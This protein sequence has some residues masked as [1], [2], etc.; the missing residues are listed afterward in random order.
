[1][2]PLRPGR[3]TDSNMSNA[4]IARSPTSD[5]LLYVFTFAGIALFGGASRPDALSQP[6]VRLVASL[7]IAYCIARPR[8]MDSKTLRWGGFL[9]GGIACLILIQLVPI[10]PALWTA[11]PGRASYAGV[12]ALTGTPLGWHAI[13]L[14]PDLGWNSFFS[15]LP[16]TAVLLCSARLHGR[17]SVILAA[18]LCAAFASALLG[19]FQ[20]VQGPESFHL[21]RGPEKGASGLFANRNHQALL[22]ACAIPLTA[23]WGSSSAK[24]WPTPWL[25]PAIAL[26]GCGA[27]ILMIPATGSRAGLALGALACLLSIPLAWSRIAQGLSRLSKRKRA[28]TLAVGLLAGSGLCAV[29]LTLSRAEAV[30]RLAS[31]NSLEDRRLA[32][33]PPLWEMA[34]TFFPFGSGF[35]SFAHVY[36]GFEPFDALA[37]T[38]LTQAHDDVL[39]FGLEGGIL[40]VGLMAGILIWWCTCSYR[41]WFARKGQGSLPGR[42]GSIVLLVIGLASTLDYPLRTPLMMAI[43]IQS[44]AWM[45]VFSSRDSARRPHFT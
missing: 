12:A 43:A 24:A 23:A 32:V 28:A 13:N 15:L 2:K 45:A 4:D 37:T 10:P 40:A 8:R 29:A 36:R 30:H 39:Q 6:V 38:Y 18:L 21:Y 16:P 9:L 7:A 5:V 19:L 44:G 22:L 42:V 11:L 1:M 34:R 35:G 14:T 20:L 33:L 27:L 31:I 17:R 25:R 3:K 26:A 41:L